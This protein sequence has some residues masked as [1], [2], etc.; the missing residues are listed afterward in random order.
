MRLMRPPSTRPMFPDQLLGLSLPEREL[1]PRDLAAFARAAC[2][3]VDWELLEPFLRF[4]PTKYARVQLCTTRHWELVAMC[5]LP[6]QGTRVHDHGGCCGASVV[7]AGSRIETSFRR[8]QG[9][10]QRSTQRRLEIGEAMFERES[11]VHQVENRTRRR[12]IS[13]HLYTPPLGDVRVFE[14][15]GDGRMT[16]AAEALGLP[17]P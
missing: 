11:T 9:R 7:L 4:D 15:R 8:R 17:P 6:G 2:K 12:A 16:T 3:G 13:L 1:K 14:P 10:L 5:W